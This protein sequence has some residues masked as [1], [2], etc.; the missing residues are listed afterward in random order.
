[1]KLLRIEGIPSPGAKVYSLLITKS[2]L[3]RDFYREVA[4]E[5]AA[6]VS[7]GRVLD[8]G[9]G[10]GYLPIEIAKRSDSLE[11]TG[12]D[13]SPAMV[14]IARRK[15]EGLGLSERIKF[16]HASAA[17]LPF[18][19]EYFDLV[20]STLSL[21]HWLRPVECLKE[22]HRVLK[23]HGEAL[24]YDLRRDTTREL[25]A[26][27]KSRYGWFLSFLLLNVVRAHSSITLGKV[28]GFLSHPEVGFSKKMVDGGIMLKL[29]LIK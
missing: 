12:I 20:V 3:T 23:E 27:L 22:I 8:V 6:K 5:V 21:H 18:E 10:P 15:V 28:E 11:I 24:I 26:E 9:T 7:S 1:M 17:N 16:Q 2:P 4:E 19:D 25:N 13:I 29:R 14:R